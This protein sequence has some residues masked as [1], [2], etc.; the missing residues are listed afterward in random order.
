M[1]Y[2]LNKIQRMDEIYTGI[3][4]LNINLINYKELG[5]PGGWQDEIGNRL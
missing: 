5:F 3:K 2:V 1:N 4:K